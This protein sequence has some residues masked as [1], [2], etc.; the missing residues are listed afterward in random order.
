MPR[1]KK[2]TPDDL[3]NTILGALAKPGRFDFVLDAV[4]QPQ[5]RIYGMLSAAAWFGGTNG[6]DEA[7]FMRMAGL[8][9]R[10]MNARRLRDQNPQA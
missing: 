7:T 2:S 8:A 9:W 10:T 3:V 1:G 5:T 6:F 4:K